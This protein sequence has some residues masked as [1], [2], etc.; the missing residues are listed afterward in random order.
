MPAAP[1]MIV[2]FTLDDAQQSEFD[3]FYQHE[4]LPKLLSIA[5]EIKNIVRYQADGAGVDAPKSNRF[6]TFY[7]LASVEALKL[8][9]EIFSRTALAA[10]MA[11]FKEWKDKHLKDFSRQNYQ[12]IYEHQR[13]SGQTHLGD[14]PVLFFSSAVEPAQV[15]AFRQWYQ[16]S[17]LP[18]LL[19]DIPLLSGCRRYS[20][21]TLAGSEKEKTAPRF[22]TMLESVNESTLAH[23][24]E[25]MSSPHR[26]KENEEMQKWL[27]SAVSF[28]ATE[29]I[30][31]IFCLPE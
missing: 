7:E 15:D 21:V 26:H 6:F 29:T 25:K 27:D 23:A 28:T 1:L 16:L 8:T 31:P 12:A 5:P 22:I 4:F 18:R 19:A 10:E 9:D 3:R 2:S 24:I 13:G 17:Y 14:R 30:R 20:S 11:K